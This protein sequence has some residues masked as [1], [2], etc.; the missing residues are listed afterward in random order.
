MTPMVNGARASNDAV[1]PD[2]E[3]SVA[4]TIAD[5]VSEA[6]GFDQMFPKW[7]G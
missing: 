6:D 2:S 1:S 3:S 4:D 7:T 5:D